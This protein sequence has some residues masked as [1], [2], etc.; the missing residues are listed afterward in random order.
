MAKIRRVYGFTAGRSSTWRALSCSHIMEEIRG[1]YRTIYSRSQ[2][3][4]WW[5]ELAMLFV[6]VV[7]MQIDLECIY[8]AYA[9]SLRTS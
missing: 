2:G 7:W 5:F 3:G 9:W 6:L 8:M 4:S 1:A